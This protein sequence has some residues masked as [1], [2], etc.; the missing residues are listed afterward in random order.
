MEELNACR[1]KCL[2]EYACLALFKRVD[3]GWKKRGPKKNSGQK[4]QV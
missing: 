1:S 2:I 4:M 3:G